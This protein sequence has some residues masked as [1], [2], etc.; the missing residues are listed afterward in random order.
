[1]DSRKRLVEI[2]DE[3]SKLEEEIS[4]FL[5]KKREVEFPLERELKDLKRKI[6]REE[7]LLRA[8][9]WKY[10]DINDDEITFESPARF[11]EEIWKLNI[12]ENPFHDVFILDPGNDEDNIYLRVDDSSLYLKLKIEYLS[13]VGDIW[14]V[15]LKAIPAIWEDLSEALCSREVHLKSLAKEMEIIKD[16][17][18]H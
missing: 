1:M 18:R 12:F 2:V 9:Q 15:N 11:L 6:I 13:K 10:L 5:A 17:L 14:G 7:G 4:D 3:L 16:L 8:G